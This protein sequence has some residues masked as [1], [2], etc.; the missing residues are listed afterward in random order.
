M[1]EEC[2]SGI[3]GHSGVSQEQTRVKLL[4][5]TLWPPNL[6][7]RTP[8]RRVMHCWIEACITAYFVIALTM[9]IGAL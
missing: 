9:P 6:V 4:K 2:I 5:N 3:E 8:D 1:E 7:G